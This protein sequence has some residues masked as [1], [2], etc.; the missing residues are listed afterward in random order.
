V[1]VPGV[2][3]PL[4]L[5]AAGSPLTMAVRS[6]GMTAAAANADSRRR[7]GGGAVVALSGSLPKGAPTNYYA[8]LVRAIQQDGGGRAVLDTSGAALEAGLRAAPWAVK[9]NRGEAEVLLGRRLATAESVGVQ[10]V[11]AARAAAGVGGDSSTEAAAAAAAAV[12]ADHAAAAAE[13][14][15]RWGVEW[16]LLSDGEAGLVVA[17]SAGAWHCRADLDSTDRAGIVN[18]QGCGDAAVAGFMSGALLSGV[19]AAVAVG[20]PPQPQQVE[21]MA[22]RAVLASTCNLFSS[23]P[24]QLSAAHLQRFGEGGA[25]ERRVRVTQI[26][27]GR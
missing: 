24:G 19:A 26:T 16:V 13:I 5:F 10:A 8:T 1:Q 23:T 3:H 14:R 20:Q 22:R 21:L 12:A 2:P 15:A 25:D 27:A 18:D 9:P 6:M 7:G 11:A 17:C 4:H